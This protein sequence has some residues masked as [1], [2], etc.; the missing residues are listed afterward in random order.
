MASLVKDYQFYK[1]FR[2]VSFLGICRSPTATV[3][4]MAQQVEQ[5]KL[6]P[7]ANM[8][9][10]GGATAAAYNVPRSAPFWLVVI[11]GGGKIQ[12]NASRGWTYR[13]GAN[14]GKFVHEIQ[15]QN[16]LKAYP[17][18]ILGV[19]DVPKA[20]ALAAHYYDLQ[21]FDL[22]EAELRKAAA[23]DDKAFAE[24]VRGKTL[25]SRQGRKLQIEDLSKTDPVQAYREATA[26]VAAFPTAPERTDVNKLG[27]ALVKETVVKREI[28][29]ESAYQQML[30]P[31]LKK[32]TTLN[33]FEKVIA[34]LV[35]AYLKGFGDTQ[36]AAAVKGACEAH[37]KAVET[38]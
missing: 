12:Y 3:K 20:M 6:K 8:L 15:I 11:D 32:T 28:A 24:L 27:Q 18:G 9:D 22:L 2:N 33:R 19:K 35:A 14:D 16:S 25:E 5:F 29:A 23:P 36:Y 30:V 38:R 13:G 10:M 21:Q 1:A 26:F 17:G 7:F 31:E 4:T 34:P 37:R